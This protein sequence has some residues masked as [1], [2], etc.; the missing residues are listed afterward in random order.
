MLIAPAATQTNTGD[1]DV[2]VSDTMAVPK[3]IV[4][5]SDNNKVHGDDFGENATSGQKE[6]HEKRAAD[7]E[8][9]ETILAEDVKTID[10]ATT[11]AQVADSAAELDEGADDFKPF[12]VCCSFC[13]LSA[14]C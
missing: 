12:L 13:L 4:E 1:A 2:E 5:K 3:L 14:N 9:D 10:F 8:P 11:A 7:A 6:A